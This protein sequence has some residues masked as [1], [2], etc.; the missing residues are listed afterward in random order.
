MWD[1]SKTNIEGRQQ[2]IV[3]SIHDIFIDSGTTLPGDKI[4]YFILCFTH[5]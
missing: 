4:F 1:V 5:L 3:L 2:K